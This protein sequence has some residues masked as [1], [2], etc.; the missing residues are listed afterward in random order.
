MPKKRNTGRRSIRP[1][2]H[3]LTEGSKT[4]INYVRG[5]INS[6]LNTIGYT[7]HDIII[8]QPTDFSPAGLLKEAQKECL[9]MDTVWIVF[10]CD[11]HPH[12]AETFRDAKTSNVHIAYSS[13][14]F[15]TW[16]LLLFIYSTRVYRNSE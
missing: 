9:D 16:L 6:Y 5:Y 2:M 7:S 12:K 11:Q 4:E 3:I 8:E 13:V 1:V 10:D 14:S 15:E